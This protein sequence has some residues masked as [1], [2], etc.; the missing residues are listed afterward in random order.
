MNPF[1]HEKDMKLVPMRE[2]SKTLQIRWYRCPVDKKILR[3]LMTP[4]DRRGCSWRL[5]ILASGRQLAASP[6]I[7]S[8]SR[9]GWGLLPRCSFTARSVHSSPRHITSFAIAP[10][11]RPNG[12][13]EAFL[14]IFALLGWNNFEIYQFSHNY[15][16]RFTL[17]PEGDR[18]EVKFC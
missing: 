10:C 18:E 13:N 6:S 16:H 9:C 8:R 7:C 1:R 2:V 17:H 15:H 3:S 12:W 14:R 11:S 5:V 4:D